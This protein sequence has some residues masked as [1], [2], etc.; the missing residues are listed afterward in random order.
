MVSV[1]G[2]TIIFVRY[3]DQ[4][5]NLITVIRREGGL[6][7]ISA[8]GEDDPSSAA[9]DIEILMAILQYSSL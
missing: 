8:T 5:N 2:A 4:K 7:L 1:A 3:K 9:L 6:Y